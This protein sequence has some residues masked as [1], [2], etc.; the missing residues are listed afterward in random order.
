[1]K[2]FYIIFL[3]LLLSTFIRSQQLNDARQ[4]VTDL[5][6][7]LAERQLIQKDYS[8]LF[9]D[10]VD[11][12]EDPLNLNTATKEDLEKIPFLT[13]HQIEEILFYVYNNGPLLTIY[14]LNAVKGLT[15]ETIEQI[16]PFLKVEPVKEQ[17]KQ[18]KRLRTEAIFR[19]QTTLQTPS[20]YRSVNDSVTAPFLG[21]RERVY[22]RIRANYGNT[23]FAGFTMEK[24]P[25]EPAFTKQVPVMDFLSGYLMLKPK[26]F[27]KKIIIGDYKA[28]FGQ[29]TGLWTAMAFTKSSVA[30]DIR[31]RA[32]G[33]DKYSSVNES[34]FLRGIAAEI[35]IKSLRLTLLGSFKKIDGTISGFS[36]I[37]SIRND[38]YH[39]TLTELGY[40][41]NVTEKIVG[42]IVSWQSNS[43]K[44]EAGQTF[45][46]IDKP[47]IPSGIPY[48]LPY[49]SG[50]SLYTTFAGYT[51]FG[52]KLILFG[53]I[54][55]QNFSNIATYQG[56][57]FSP[58]AGVHL[59]VSYRN[60]SKKCFF[61]TANPF[62]ES[63]VMNGES[64]IYTGLS[65]SPV[66]NLTLNSYFDVF[67]YK[68]LKYRTD[69]PSSGYELLFQG[70]Y[71]FF[72][73]LDLLLRY[74]NNSKQGNRLFYTSNDFPV[75][76][77]RLHSVRL[78]IT[79]PISNS[80]WFSSRIEQTFF[81]EEKG[82]SSNGF[83]LF[84]DVKH[85]FAK[86]KLSGDIRLTHFDTDDYY[87]KIYTWE[88]DLL[89]VFSVPSFSGKG[90]RFLF[91]MS[92]KPTKRIQFWLRAANTYRPDVKE[93]GSG[94]NV[95]PGKNLTEIKF[96]IRIKL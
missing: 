46:K 23:L 43:L 44:I 80:W 7:P 38:G 93:I 71:S 92:Y 72:S 61:I 32:T 35:Q 91:N 48:K 15:P 49:F 60:Y 94:Y 58:G 18:T 95:V 41:K 26:G 10:L 57:T 42:G 27:F 13:D 75:S 9:N 1:M 52:R 59:A 21:S 78:N 81:R 3:L 74:R 89:Y 76:N 68:W 67:W 31:R 56:L 45:W 34:S 51:W 20:G 83:L 69:A 86:T 85:T 55:L 29:G 84:F 36:G 77:R 17:T 5:L 96:Q 64:G 11:M 25:G 70:T 87:S 63:S 22:T 40:R 2:R 30:T 28:S 54:A 19:G 88:P 90:L 66:K 24:D 8:E 53:E 37:T 16:I 39:R 6:E 4:A 14:E 50:D 12:Y 65:F 47:I 73:G 79:Y 33:I 62:A 82:H